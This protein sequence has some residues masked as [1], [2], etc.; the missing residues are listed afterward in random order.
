MPKRAAFG[1]SLFAVD[2]NIDF[3]VDVLLDRHLQKNLCMW[4][5]GISRN[6]PHSQ[7]FGGRL[8]GK[9]PQ[10]SKS[11]QKS[12]IVPFFLNGVTK[13]IFNWSSLAATPSAWR[14]SQIATKLRRRTMISKLKLTVIAAVAALSIAVPTAAMAQSAYTTGTESNRVAAGY[15]SP[16]ND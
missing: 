1:T 7:L 9:W 11:P 2:G 5:C 3:V 15:P 13:K 8:L 6:W 14:W 12:K 10:A 16:Y 4:R